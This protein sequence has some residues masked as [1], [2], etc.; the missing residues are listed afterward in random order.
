MSFYQKIKTGTNQAYLLVSFLVCP[1]SLTHVFPHTGSCTRYLGSLSGSKYYL[2]GNCNCRI[3]LCRC[4][5]LFL[6]PSPLVNWENIQ[7]CKLFWDKWVHALVK[8]S[9]PQCCFDVRIVLDN[10]WVHPCSWVG[11]RELCLW[12]INNVNAPTNNLFLSDN[13]RKHI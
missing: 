10:P 7:N 2:T 9:L 1:F 12:I 8:A 3:L 5:Y 13:N 4:R 11:W 6:K